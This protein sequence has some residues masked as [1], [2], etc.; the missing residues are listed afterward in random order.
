MSLKKLQTDGRIKPHTTSKTEL[1][2]LRGGV[3]VKLKDSTSTSIS[4]DTRFTIA[5]GAAI[6]LAKMA[7]ACAGYRLDSKSGGHHVT[8]FS[9]LRLAIG[10]S[11]DELATFF[12]VCRRKRNEIDYD[13]AHVASRADADEIVEKAN[14]LE[15]Q[16]EDWIKTNH[17][18]LAK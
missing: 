16:V 15:A 18:S 17:P 5:Y 14:E 11:V 8:A 10:K 4:D 12:E 9:A 7:L 3:L 1:D 13:R 2:E 6:L